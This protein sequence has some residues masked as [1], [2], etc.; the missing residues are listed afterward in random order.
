VDRI[1]RGGRLSY[2]WKKL[3]FHC[4]IA[5]L[6]QNHIDIKI[7]DH[8]CGRWR[9][10]GCYGMLVRRRRIEFWNLL[11][12]LSNLSPL[13]WCIIRDFNDILATYEKKVRSERQ[14]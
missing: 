2:L 11:R 13:P 6:S 9:L 14:L 1:G 4:S 8:V 5:N 12:Q 7:V 10:V 3:F